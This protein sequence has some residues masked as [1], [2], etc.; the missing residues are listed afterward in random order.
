MVAMSHWFGQ[1]AMTPH[2]RENEQPF[3]QTAVCRV[4]LEV[5]SGIHDICL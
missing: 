3:S 1:W 2:S 5:P 4:L